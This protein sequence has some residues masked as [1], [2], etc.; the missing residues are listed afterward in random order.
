MKKL[1]VL[2]TMIGALYSHA[3]G[4]EIIATEMPKA[5]ALLAS[6]KVDAETTKE[7]QEMIKPDI[8][9]VDQA[10]TPATPAEIKP[11]EPIPAPTPVAE[12]TKELTPT[13]APEVKNEQPATPVAPVVEPVKPAEPAAPTIPIVEQK[14]VQPEVVPTASGEVKN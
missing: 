9:A 6:E 8:D 14:T 1:I 12:P 10:A 3:I 13:P 11:T 2:C 4:Q 5:P 7:L